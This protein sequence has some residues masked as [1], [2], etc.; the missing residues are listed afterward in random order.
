MNASEAR[1]I[2]Q[3]NVIPISKILD[4]IANNAQTGMNSINFI[5]IEIPL[6]LCGELMD[7]GYKISKGTSPFGESLTTIYW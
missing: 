2:T 5:G 3:Q 4:G 1:S 6:P 7:L